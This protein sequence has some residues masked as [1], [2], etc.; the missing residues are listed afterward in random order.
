MSETLLTT[1]LARI[2]I[3]YRLAE[4][5]ERKGLSQRQLAELTGIHH[6]NIHKIEHGKINLTIDKLTQIAD[7]LTCHV[8]IVRGRD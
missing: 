5:R 2:R 1:Q 7:A 3:G 4:L 8:D 6:I